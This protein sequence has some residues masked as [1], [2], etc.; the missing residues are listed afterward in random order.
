MYTIIINNI[1]I[2]SKINECRLRKK[3]MITDII[4]ILKNESCILLVKLIMY[5]V[6]KINYEPYY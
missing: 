4:N 6:S 3:I 2:K 1:Y 5:I